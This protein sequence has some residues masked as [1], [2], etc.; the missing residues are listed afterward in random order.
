MG[1]GHGDEMGDA[2][3]GVGGHR[4]GGVTGGAVGHQCERRAGVRPE[5]VEGVAQ[6]R[7]SLGEIRGGRGEDHEPRPG[8]VDLGELG[9][10]GAQPWRG[11]IDGPLGGLVGPVGQPRGA[12]NHE[13]LAGGRGKVLGAVDLGVEPRPVR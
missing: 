4:P 1:G 8:P 13:Q 11:Q 10:R 9:G 6:A 5:A 7:R 2:G 12:A 3:G